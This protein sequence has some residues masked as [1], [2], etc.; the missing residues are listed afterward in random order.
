MNIGGIVY[1]N[2]GTLRN[3]VFV[4]TLTETTP[5]RAGGIAGVVRASSAGQNNVYMAADAATHGLV[6]KDETESYTTTNALATD[7]AAFSGANAAM[8]ATFD[9]HVW[10]LDSG[11]ALNKGCLTT[12][13]ANAG[14][15][16]E[17]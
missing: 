15:G 11:F 2:Y 13:T 5:T 9:T 8:L 16:T 3:N 1:E 7:F 4:G 12:L 10:T 17:A 14:E 6:G